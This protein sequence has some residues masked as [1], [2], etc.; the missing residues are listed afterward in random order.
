[1]IEDVVLSGDEETVAGRLRELFDWGATEVL[2][3]PITAGGDASASMD[4]SLNLI[5]TVGQG[6]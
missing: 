3:H 5:A 6:L 4:R 2:A 1:M